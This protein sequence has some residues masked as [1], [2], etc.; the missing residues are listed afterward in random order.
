MIPSDGPADQLGR[1]ERRRGRQ[2]DHRAAAEIV[3]GRVHDLA[4]GAQHLAAALVVEEERAAEDRRPHLVQ[5][6]LELGDDSEV[7][8][9]AAQGPEQVGVLVARSRGRP[10]RKR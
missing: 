10:R 9:A 2:V 6:E 3:V 5:L 1:D 4:V 8:S 7:A